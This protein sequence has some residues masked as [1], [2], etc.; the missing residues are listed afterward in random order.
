M[1][2]E[3][4]IGIIPPLITPIDDNEDVDEE[5]FRKLINH[6][7]EKGLHGI[8]VSGSNGET[9]AL[10]Q[11]QRNRAIKIALDEVNRK[12]P[13]FCGVMDTSTRRV[14]E[15]IKKLEQI[16]GE[17]AVITPVFYSRNTCQQE[18]V[19]HF[20]EIARKTDISIMIYNIPQFTQVNIKPEKV[21]ELSGIDRVIGLKES[22]GNILQLQKCLQYFKDRKFKIFQ[23]T[24]DIA[25]ISVLMGADGMVPVLAPLF[26]E[27]FLE[28]Y[29]GARERNVQKTLLLQEIICKT[30]NILSMSLNATSAAKYAISLIGF[31]SKRV[32][33]PCEPITEEQEE[34]IKKLVESINIEY[35]KFKN[36]V[37]PVQ[38]YAI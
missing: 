10:T 8:F 38:Q 14:V 17:I 30:S 28:M 27:I 7:A 32:T 35:S 18:I 24:T 9:M 1:D 19:R 12:F 22:G 29:N 11:E 3:K 6:C 33:V 13:V 15:N 26:P 16:G 34:K 5:G 37:L 36:E 2:I 20:E 21:I 31:S 4:I 25:G 23:G